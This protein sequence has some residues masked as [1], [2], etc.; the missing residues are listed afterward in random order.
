MSTAEP[1]EL[2]YGLQ[3]RDCGEHRT[4]GGRAWCFDCTEWCSPEVPCTRCELPGIRAELERLRAEVAAARAS[5]PAP[6]PTG[7]GDGHGAAPATTD[8]SAGRTEPRDCD[9]ADDPRQRCGHHHT[10]D[11][12]N[13]MGGYNCCCGWAWLGR[14]NEC[15]TGA[16]TGDQV[17]LCDYVSDL[18]SYVASTS[19]SADFDAQA[20]AVIPAIEARVRAQALA[21]LRATIEHQRE[22]LS[23]AEPI[24]LGGLHEQAKRIGEL[25]RIIATI[26][27]IAREGL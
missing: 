16:K 22:Q 18:L 14:A 27:R 25:G 13:A 4:C 19:G 20:A 26:D 10:T 6:G 11:I 8:G 1:D 17:P 9:G 24:T 15:S 12:G 2:F 7:P 21:D 3:P 23:V 5:Q